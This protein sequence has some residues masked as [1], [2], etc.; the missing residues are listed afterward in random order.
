MPHSSTPPY[1][2]VSRVSAGGDL[3]GGENAVFEAP[4]RLKAALKAN[5]TGSLDTG[6]WITGI[7]C[8]GVVVWNEMTVTCMKRD[9]QKWAKVQREP[10]GMEKGAPALKSLLRTK[11][12]MGFKSPALQCLRRSFFTSVVP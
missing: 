12:F 9:F 4:E 11:I 3:T 8:V 1:V 10:L 2:D 5:G 6:K 7:I